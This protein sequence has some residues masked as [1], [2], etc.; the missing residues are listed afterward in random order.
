MF[1]EYDAVVLLL[2]E[3]EILKMNQVSLDTFAV[4]EAVFDHTIDSD[5]FK[6]AG[7]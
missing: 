1:A 2:F 6:V 3:I 7:P 5:N 4:P